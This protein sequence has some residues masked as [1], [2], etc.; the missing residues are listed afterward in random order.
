MLFQGEYEL[1][2]KIA[3]DYDVMI[4][5]LAE[6]FVPSIAEAFKIS[7]IKLFT[8]PVVRSDRYAPPTGLPFITENKWMNR[9]QWDAALVR[10]GMSF[11]TTRR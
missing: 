4:N 8:F 9:L 6:I 7:N 10:P 2:S 3:P 5:F 1:L 11:R